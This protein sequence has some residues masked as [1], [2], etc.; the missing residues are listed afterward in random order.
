ME[1]IDYIVSNSYLTKITTDNSSEVIV[2]SIP[3]IKTN[4][5]DYARTFINFKTFPYVNTEYGFLLD[6][7]INDLDLESRIEVNGIIRKYQK[8][9]EDLLK[10]QFEAKEDYLSLSDDER[11]ECLTSIKGG[12]YAEMLLMNILIDLGYSKILSKLYLEVGEGHPSP[13]LIDVPCIKGKSLVLGECKLYSNIHEAIKSV[14]KDLK[15]IV[16]KDKFDKEFKEWGRKI[17]Q[18]PEKIKNYIIS[19]NPFDDKNKLVDD[20][21]EIVVTGFVM[22]KV[23]E[24]LIKEELEKY[25]L[26]KSSNVKFKIYLILVPISDKKA[27]IN[28]CYKALSTIGL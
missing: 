8:E 18:I 23:D 24:S 15:D 13:S 21:D 25:P 5:D 20:L 3:N 17:K 19:F 22:G 11:I 7:T 26:P 1:T 4:I 16:E 27:F 9:I 2:F 6:S 14:N 28:A 10:K 12:Q